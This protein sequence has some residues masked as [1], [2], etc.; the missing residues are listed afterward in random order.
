ML[1]WWL[2]GIK[3]SPSDRSNA[4]GLLAFMGTC[5]RANGNEGILPKNGRSQSGLA[6]PGCLANHLWGSVLASEVGSGSREWQRHG[7][8]GQS[9]L[10]QVPWL[11]GDGT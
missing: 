8:K 11:L 5:Q 2:S 3:D 10:H 7:W 4:E 1:W 9:L 6:R